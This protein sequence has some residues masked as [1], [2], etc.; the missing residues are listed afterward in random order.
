MKEGNET[1]E[2]SQTKISE[3]KGPEV[4]DACLIGEGRVED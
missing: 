2:T 4:G 3:Y 1:A